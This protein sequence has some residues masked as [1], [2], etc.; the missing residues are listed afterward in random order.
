VSVS[1]EEAFVQ[2]TFACVTMKWSWTVLC[3]VVHES[4]GQ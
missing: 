3:L 2:T 4:D 1:I